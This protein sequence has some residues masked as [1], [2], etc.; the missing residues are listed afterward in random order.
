ME[1][2]TA[3]EKLKEVNKIIQPY[4]IWMI[5]PNEAILLSKNARHMSKRKMLALT[6]NIRQDGFLSQLPFAIRRNDGKFEIISGN[7]RVKACIA[8]GLESIPVL[9]GE[10]SDFSKDRRV[11]IQI[12]HNSIFGD[13]DLQILK[14]LYSELDSVD[15][16]RYSCIDEEE[17]FKNEPLEMVQIRADDFEM[18][19]I[20]F[21][22]CDSKIE[23]IEET[24]E[25]L[26]KMAMTKKTYK[27]IGE[28]ND[29]LEVFTKWSTR[30][31]VRSRSVAFALMCDL[32][33]EWMEKNNANKTDCK[34][35][36]E[37]Q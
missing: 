9:F 6:E 27:V 4:K 1:K 15:Y 30:N 32:C 7:H 2:E 20:Q 22:F 25:K 17:L 23:K 18:T 19:P 36:K 13:D 37:V 12:S 31:N 11:A 14:E 21:V 10:E 3:N 34:E 5:D 35:K 33:E 26:E 16:K 28:V 29:F 8:A 24:L